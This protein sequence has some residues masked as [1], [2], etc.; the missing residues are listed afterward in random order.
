MDNQNSTAKVEIVYPTL[1]LLDEAKHYN[2]V[3]LV[4]ELNRLKK[5]VYEISQSKR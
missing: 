2:N 1:E 4:R 3:D 5:E